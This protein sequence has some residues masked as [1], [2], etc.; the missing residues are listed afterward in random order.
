M[1]EREVESHLRRR[2]RELG[3]MCIKLAPTES[4]L[5]DRLVLLPGGWAYLVELKSPTGR[6][7]PV[8]QV[9]HQRAA[10]ID[11]PVAIL[12]CKDD[13]AT[14]LHCV[15]AQANYPL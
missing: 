10:D 8:Q 15:A 4:G 5:P 2:V 11:H 3:G 14:W 9:W 13:V 12:R 1:R 6:L 7:R